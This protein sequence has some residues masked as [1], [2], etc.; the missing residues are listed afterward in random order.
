[1]LTPRPFLVP[2][3]EDFDPDKGFQKRDD[4]WEGEDEGLDLEVYRGVG[5]TQAVSSVL[6]GWGC[7]IS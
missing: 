5:S 4:R 2:D 6:E 1:M 3:A 7:S